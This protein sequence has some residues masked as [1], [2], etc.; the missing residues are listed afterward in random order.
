LL[1]RLQNALDFV[2]IH[3][4]IEIRHRH[5]AHGQR[6]ARLLG[7]SLRRGAKDRVE[8]AE[9]GRSPDDETPEVATRGELEQV[10]GRNG[11]LIEEKTIKKT[12]D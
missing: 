3:Q 10:E 12:K 1:R 2:G 11:A 6:V 8:L 9:S 4:F 7:R 5:V